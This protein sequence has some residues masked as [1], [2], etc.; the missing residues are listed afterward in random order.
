MSGRRAT[1]RNGGRTTCPD[2]GRHRHCDPNV[3]RIP[4]PVPPATRSEL[5]TPF[6]PSIEIDLF[7]N[8]DKV[9][10]RLLVVLTALAL[11]CAFPVGG[12]S[13]GLRAT[14]EGLGFR[15][16]GGGRRATW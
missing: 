3:G 6:K 11:V 15:V 16:Q 7:E 13:W 2:P 10:I 1:W 14:A 5:F 4:P 8:L 9:H 12:G